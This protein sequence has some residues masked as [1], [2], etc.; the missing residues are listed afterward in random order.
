MVDVGVVLCGG[1][2]K[3]L[4]TSGVV[5]P[6]RFGLSFWCTVIY[7]FEVIGLWCSPRISRESA[8]RVRI[9]RMVVVSYAKTTILR[10]F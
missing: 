8:G 2:C 1:L 7:S 10:K 4:P 5:C 6:P 9:V 3:W